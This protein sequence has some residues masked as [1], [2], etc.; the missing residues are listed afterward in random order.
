MS[1]T[2]SFL[3][4]FAGLKT[5]TLADIA[6]DHVLSSALSNS[7]A[8][9]RIFWL[10]MCCPKATFDAEFFHVY[11]HQVERV[12]NLYS[13]DKVYHVGCVTVEISNA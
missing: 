6:R 7:M 13:A 5:S 2:N 12:C 1:I 4:S 8:A 11:T 10:S 3:S 9:L